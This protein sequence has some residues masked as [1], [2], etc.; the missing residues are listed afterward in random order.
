MN[1]P[2]LVEPSSNGFRASIQ[3]PL[4]LAAEGETENAAMAALMAV[5]HGDLPNGGKI[6]MLQLREIESVQAICERMSSSPIHAEM[7]EA[8]EEYRKTVNVVDEVD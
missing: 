4:P 5:L 7:E 2:M 8:F 3:S 1:I 6:R